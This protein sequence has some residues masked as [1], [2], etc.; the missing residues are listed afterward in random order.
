MA[1]S[2]ELSIGVLGPVE[3]V[4]DGELL[5]LG[6]PQQRALIAHLALD[7]GRVVPVE[8]LIDRLWGD[9][10]PR[11]GLGTLQSYVSRL[12]R[13]LEPG[14]PAGTAA[15]VLV[16][17]APGYAL[18]VP[19][20]AVDVHRFTATLAEAR[21]SAAAGYAAQALAQFDAALALWRGEALAGVGP[22]EQVRPIVLR[23]EE[24]RA[25]AVEERFDAMLA[26]G[27]HAEA[28]PA[29]QAAVEQAPLREGLWASLALA[30]YRSSRQ[31]EALRA[32]SAARAA[33]LDE[34]GL[35]PGPELRELEGRILSQDPALLAVPAAAA[36]V[37]IDTTPVEA[38][39]SELVGRVAEWDALAHAL[40]AAGRGAAQVALVEGE[41]G[42]G[43]STVCEAFVAHAR[44]SGWR[45]AT[46]RCVESGLAPSLWPAIEV[47][48]ALVGDV[49]GDVRAAA[50]NPL[51]QF[52][53]ADDPTPLTLS[54]VELADRFAELIDALGVA[55]L[56]VLLDDIHWADQ[57]TLDVMVLA[58]ERLGPRRVLVIGAHR[59]PELVPG[60][61]L[62]AALGRLA[63]NAHVHRVAMTPLDAA[64]VSRLIELT[65][66]TAPDAE[67][68]ER[69]R[70]RAGGNPLFV[71]ELARLAGERGI[72]DAAQVPTA[73]RD[74]VRSRLAQ[75][76]PDTTRELQVAA[77]IGGWFD[78]RTVMAAS[79]GDPDSC[80][81]AL[82][83]AIVTRIVVPDGDGDAYGYGFAH[84]LVRDAVLADI[85][86]L[87]RARLHARVADALLATYGD[88]PDQAEPI[89]H[90]RL[91]A[92]GVG[93]PLV[94]ARAA[95]RAADV[96][97]WRG[98][99]DAG[100]ELA[101]RALEVLVGVPRTY[102]VEM[103]E[104]LA[105]EAIAGT[106][107]RRLG[108]DTTALK[109]EIAERVLAFGERL[110]HD[111]ARALGLFLAWDNIDER[112]DLRTLDDTAVRALA[113]RT[114]DRYAVVTTG[115]MIGAYDLLVG[116][117]H[118]AKSRLDAV[119]ET[120][121]GRPDE[122]PEHVPLVLAPV[123]SA[124]A[125]AVAGDAETARVNAHQRTA[126][127]LSARAEVDRTAEDAIAFTG[128]LIDALLDDPSGVRSVLAK[129]P[130][131]D[132]GG[133]LSHQAAAATLLDAWAEVRLGDPGAAERALAQMS[134]IERSEERVLRS[135]L[136]TFA[137]A[138]LLEAGDPRAVA[139]L[140]QAIDDARS[141][142]EVWWLAETLRLRAIADTAFA[143]GSRAAALREEAI[144]LA[145]E[146][147]AHLVL[148]RLQGSA[149]AA[150]A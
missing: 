101:E 13:V 130:I 10:P 114:T 64:D 132:T 46:G 24:E 92:I 84:A 115:Y 148:A 136:R 65:I 135:M 3:V 22:D 82:D 85:T 108:F 34:L 27:R 73:I 2:E 61:R 124:I 40:E 69:V 44:A 134:T 99:L 94:A 67:I 78:V 52:A 137:G 113:E 8:R 21:R 39:G 131:A 122:R 23:F 127:W 72:T 5:D 53:T 102:E 49:P 60:T 62:G 37:A 83:A 48:R 89:A 50:A 149:A 58:A 14:R 141:R 1:A 121:G 123:T 74:V 100:D 15:Q 95:V 18:R 25:Q 147:G 7:V 119:I 90:H 16:S 28:V 103:V 9:D 11:T 75:L 97:R 104:V 116:R 59:P 129:T 42:I 17:E 140:D 118:D 29:L 144:A 86:P 38:R 145:T 45:T 41:P 109:G 106:A 146:Q 107:F 117:V 128:V 6:G 126:A 31:A 71:A 68:A 87:R 57:A 77:T 63:R 91:A 105:L 36:P 142:N 54:P 56:V 120:V 66:G 51:Y 110:D 81:D 19:P 43:K 32:L 80:L 35:D 79:D 139:Q 20:E 26:L 143:D 133:F 55:P 111:G 12:R 33:L 96:A 150:S 47:V 112:E 88:G 138:A 70:S 30:L 93:D 4:R 76:P 125:S 98:A